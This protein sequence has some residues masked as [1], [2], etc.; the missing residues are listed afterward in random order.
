MYCAESFLS[1]QGS[2][3]KGSNIVRQGI[4]YV[5]SN[6]LTQ[7]LPDNLI[8]K[9]MRYFPLPLELLFTFLGSNFP[10][11]INYSGPLL[12]EAASRIL[13]PDDHGVHSSD[14]VHSL[15]AIS[16]QGRHVITFYERIRMSTCWGASEW[17]VARKGDGMKSVESVLW[18][19]TQRHWKS[20]WHCCG[21]TNSFTKSSQKAKS[22]IV[23]CKPRRT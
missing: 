21:I 19:S 7:V 8:L 4:T 16:Q 22:Y 10:Q 13:S 23:T 9:M 17:S 12:S 20:P 5:P 2:S 14:A 1:W 6:H 18:T 11:Q 3:A 15:R